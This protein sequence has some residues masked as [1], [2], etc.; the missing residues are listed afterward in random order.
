MRVLSKRLHRLTV[1]GQNAT[2]ELA[3]VVEENVL[4]W[5]IV[6]LHGAAKT[7]AAR[8][9]RTSELLRRLSLKSTVAA[10]TMTPVTQ[11]LAACAM[12]AVIVDRAVAKR[13]DGRDGR[14]LRRL[15]HRD[16][17]AGGADQAPVR[18][19]RADHA[20]PGGGRARHHA[21]RRQPGP[22]AAAAT[23]PGA[24]QRPHRAAR[25]DAALSRRPT[26]RAQRRDL[27]LQPGRDGRAG[28]PVGRRQVD[29]RQPAAAL[30]RA[31]RRRA[32]ARRP[33]ARRLG[34]RARCAASS[35]S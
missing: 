35:R 19:R 11:V 28:R 22:S 3:Y 9:G 4:A 34:H 25:R 15:R 14:R 8:F 5:R 29:A 31:E 33:A 32:A 30:H 10:S 23:T 16:A 7:E 2:D 12:S 1:E 21:D 20:R 18:D 6:R 26:A 27:D 17:D 24:R 13:S